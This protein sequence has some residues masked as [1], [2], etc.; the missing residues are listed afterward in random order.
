LPLFEALIHVGLKSGIERHTAGVI[1]APRTRQKTRRM[2]PTLAFE[3]AF[4]KAV[5]LT[6]LHDGVEVLMPTRLRL[7]LED[8]L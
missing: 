4:S 8:L 5:G 1:G 6:W 7:T 2:L 3:K